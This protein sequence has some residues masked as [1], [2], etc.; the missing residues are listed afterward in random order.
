MNSNPKQYTEHGCIA[1]EDTKTPLVVILLDTESTPK[2]CVFIGPLKGEVQVQKMPCAAFRTK[3]MPLC[4]GDDH[5]PNRW[6]REMLGLR[7]KHPK[8][9]YSLA[10]L[11]HLERIVDLE[12]RGKS[13][14]QIHSEVARLAEQLPQ[15]HALRSVP[16]AYP[17]RVAAIAALIALRN[18][19]YFSTTKES[20]MAT[21]KVG[22]QE[23][24]KGKP[25]A[26]DAAKPDAGKAAD[27]K[28]GKG[29]KAGKAADAKPE[30]GKAADAKPEKKKG[31]RKGAIDI[32]GPFKVA[33]DAVKAKT[34]EELRLHEGSARHK[35]MTYVFANAKAKGAK[36]F[37][38]EELTKV[39]GDQTK[40]ALT[41]M[42]KYGFL[43]KA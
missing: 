43:A 30:A 26:A 7:A 41:G 37:T 11:D 38:L 13:A 16:K 21:K 12:T 35:L 28:P 31:T 40:Q 23:D 32:T 33:G 19:V 8:M 18:G 22:K 5:S 9:K 36:G 34:P 27:A 24:T 15:G 2:S 20:T 17:D 39:T 1:G 10:A 3:F 6:A 4:F 42:V 29:G 14:E 25:D